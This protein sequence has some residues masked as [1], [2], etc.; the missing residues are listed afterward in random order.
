MYSIECGWVPVYRRLILICC[1]VLLSQIYKYKYSVINTL[2]CT[3]SERARRPASQYSNV[4]CG[5]FDV[6]L[7]SASQLA[8][9]KLHSLHIQ[10]TQR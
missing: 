8:R 1:Y 2:Y 7:A 5:S 6:L 9:V 10:T 4:L 3:P